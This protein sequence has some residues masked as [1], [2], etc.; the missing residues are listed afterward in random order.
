MRKELEKIDGNR[1]NFK[2]TFVHYGQ[3]NSYMGVVGTILLKDITD[4]T[5]KI[6]TDHLW[7]N[8]I[9]GFCKLDL[10]PGEIISFCARVKPYIKGYRGHR[11][12]DE[13]GDYSRIETDYKLSHPTK[14]KKEKVVKEDKTICLLYPKII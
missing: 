10:Q 3:K 2:A 4:I 14:I 1:Q 7:F 11:D 8:A 5:G 6:V 12:W 13:L 9:K